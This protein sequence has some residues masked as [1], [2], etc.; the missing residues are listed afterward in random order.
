MNHDIAPKPTTLWVR[1]LAFA[2]FVGAYATSGPTMEA[3][4]FGFPRCVYGFA[5]GAYFSSVR[6]NISFPD[7]PFTLVEIA[8]VGLGVMFVI[9][10]GDNAGSFAAPLVFVVLIAVFSEEKGVVSRILLAPAFRRIGELSYSIYMTHVLVIML[11]IN[12]VSLGEKLFRCE[13]RTSITVGGALLKGVGLSLWQ[14]DIAYVAFLALVIA[15][16]SL[17]FRFIESP[18]RK[19][20]RR[21]VQG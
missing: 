10:A 7:L 11:G 3:T 20:S 1:A 13:L 5:I 8:A 16:A 18:G 2:G 17:T 12:G 9:F 6:N 19:F 21:V 15:A 4:A 14:G